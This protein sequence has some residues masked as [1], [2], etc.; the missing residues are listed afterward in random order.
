ML[1]SRPLTTC[2][3]KLTPAS[4][5]YKLESFKGETTPS[6]SPL[7][8]I[9]K[10]ARGGK[11]PA[12]VF[13]SV[14]AFGYLLL[15]VFLC[16]KEVKETSKR[17]VQVGEIVEECDLGSGKTN[18]KETSELFE[19]VK[20]HDKHIKVEIAAAFL[21]AL[22]CGI[23]TSHS[24]NSIARGLDTEKVSLIIEKK[25]RGMSQFLE[26][27]RKHLETFEREI[28]EFSEKK[29]LLK[30]SETKRKRPVES[31]SSQGRSLARTSE[32]IEE[33]AKILL[34]KANNCLIRVKNCLQS[35]EEI[36]QKEVVSLASLNQQEFDF[37]RE[38]IYF[39][40]LGQEKERI[41][42]DIVKLFSEID[43]QTIAPL[44]TPPDVTLLV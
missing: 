21:L 20:R 19:E 33:K 1:N 23:S 34:N 10:I 31:E 9:A 24:F 30:Q 28:S 14:V 16:Y 41:F 27:G 22:I 42:R 18:P 38:A 2:S 32:D 39:R 43:S 15:V 35:M 44:D 26:K 37:K 11:C 12:S 36:T 8:L 17:R 5:L 40:R 13:V 29:A 3:K 25:R 6:F 4:N 7:V